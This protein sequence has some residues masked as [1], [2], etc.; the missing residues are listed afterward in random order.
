MH[1]YAGASIRYKDGLYVMTLLEYLHARTCFALLLTP[2]HL[3]SSADALP[4]QES[5]SEQE[6]IYN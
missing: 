2:G 3:D 4:G 1:C 6:S 5:M